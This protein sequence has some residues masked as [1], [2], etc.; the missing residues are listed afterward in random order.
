MTAVG[1][2]GTVKSLVYVG[3]RQ[4]EVVELSAIVLTDDEVA[5]RVIATGIC[6]SDV[7]GFKGANGR[8]QPGQVMGHE[9]V[10]RVLDPGTSQ[11]L[12]GQLCTVNPVVACGE[13]EM[14]RSDAEQACVRRHVMGVDPTF[15]SAFAEVVVVPA[16]NVILM[17]ESMPEEFGALVEPLAVG[18]HAVKRAACG[19]GDRVL[20]IGGGPVGQAAA[21]AAVRQGA[22]DVLVSE[23]LGPR[24]DLCA[25][26][27]LAVIDPGTVSDEA[28][29]AES[30]RRLGGLATLV[31]DAVGSSAT[32]KQAVAASGFRARIVL[33]GM[34][35]TALN[36]DAFAI[37]T[38]ERSLIGSFAYSAEDFAETAEWVGTAPRELARIIDRRIGLD[39]AP[40]AF[41]AMARGELGA[42]KVLVFPAIAGH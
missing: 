11:L 32:I 20:V 19:A 27:G 37:S 21:L 5:I 18:L 14:C 26:L 8:R 39:E 41:E 16:R 28:F 30:S 25:Q 9:M 33:V 3:P 15:R 17:P 42:G 31:V 36:V 35:E 13:C 12:L 1:S 34:S 7:H 40:G 22:R 23:P 38:E 24:R 6:G 10:G 29:V 4:L 2:T